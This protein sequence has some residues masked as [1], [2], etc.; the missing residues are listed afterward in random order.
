MFASRLGVILRSES[1]YQKDIADRTGLSEPMVSR[2][3]GGA[4]TPATARRIIAAFPLESV[5]AELV[6]AFIDDCLEQVGVDAVAAARLRERTPDIPP[7]LV[8]V[9]EALARLA[10]TDSEF[11]SVL[12][13]MAGREMTRPGSVSNP[14]NPPNPPN[15]RRKPRRH[16]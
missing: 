16:G 11:E 1:L 12:R 6:A 10:A 9:M 4:Y 5:R 2:A 13:Y 3:L 7:R 8:P 14:P 15:P